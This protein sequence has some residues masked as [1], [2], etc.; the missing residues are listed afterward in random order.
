MRSFIVRHMLMAGAGATALGVSL[1]IGAAP[2]NAQASAEAPAQ[3]II[4]T[5]SRIARRD[6]EANSPLVTVGQDSFES[7]SSSSV[8]DTLNDLPQFTPGGSASLSSSA[9][10][11]F[12][13]ADQAP[14]AATLDLRGLGANR[15]LVLVNGRRAQPV[16]AQLVVDVNTIPSSAVKNVEVITGGAAAVYGADAIAGVVNFILRDDFEGFELN[17][18]AGLSE[19]G[20]AGQFQVS[21]LIGGNFANGRGNA[22]IG[23]SWS[24]RK[25]AYQ[26][27]RKFYTNAWN[28]PATSGGGGAI[29][30]TVAVLDGI[31]YGVNPD[32][33]LFNTADALNPAAP[34]TGP[35][36]NLTGGAGLKLNPPSPGSGAR[37]VGYNDP[38]NYNSIPLKRY[39]LFGAAH[40]DVTD[41]IEA[42]FEGNYTHSE[43]YAQ[44]FAGQAGNIW[45][46]SMPYD[47]G[48]DD[49]ASPTFGADQSNFHPVSRQLAALL[50]NR[51]DPSANWT[52]SRGLNFLGRLYTETSSD[53][54]QLT[55]GLRGE[56][57]VKDWT[58]ELYGSHGQTTVVARQPQGAISYAN[59]QQLITGN[60]S[61][62]GRSPTI[63]G[64]WNA[65]WTSGATFNPTSCTSGIPIFNADGSVP[66]PAAGSPDG[67]IVSDDCKNYATLELNNITKLQQ[68]I[69]EGTMQG[70]LLNNWA[71]EVRFAVGATYRTADFSYAPDTG[72]SG[73]QP[74]TGVVN[75][76]ALPNPTR[77]DIS[78]KEVYGELLVPL[79]RDL[80][81]IKQ[82]DLEL[83][84]RYSK[85][86]LSG[87]IGT[88]KALADWRVTDWLRLRGGYQKANRAPNIYELF[89]PIA[90]GLGTSQDPCVNIAGFTPEFGNVASNPNRVN[91]QTACEALIVRDGGFDYTTLAEDPTAVDQNPSLYPNGLDRTRMS[92]HRWTLGYNLPFPF[93]IGLTQGNTELKSEKADTI[94]IGAVINA[95]FESP[96][97]RRLTLT[98][99]YYSINLKGTIGA[100]NGVEIYTQCLSPEYN[101]RMSSA[102]GT[103]D[104]TGLLEG[105]PFCALINRYPFDEAGVR[106]AVGSGTDRT[107][108]APFLNKG[109]TKTSGV[110][111]T[112]NWTFDLQDVGLG[113]PGA[114]NFNGS[115]NILLDYK[116]ASFE[117]ASFVDLKG[118]LD[119][120]AFDYK[121]FGTLSY[122]WSGG[123]VGL[124]GRYLPSIAPSPFSAA[125]TQG[126]ASHTEFDLFGRFVVNDVIEL[127]AGVDNLFNAQPEIV[128]ATPTNAN[129]GSTLSVYD[130]IGRA[131]YLGAKIRF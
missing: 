101:S 8:E 119:N 44:S 26:R 10:T 32:G 120:M 39:T 96:L 92:N 109:G 125:G 9:G 51:A 74:G 19:H 73:E 80:P 25:P 123:S 31:N 76:I 11:A 29:P 67:V 102:A 48:N 72:N 118:T 42:F 108:Q 14:G 50:N 49:P 57:G 113:I 122:L 68:N 66:V 47:P 60:A 115:A 15:T 128:G 34:Y 5:G 77:G 117:G 100:P 107:Y 18:Q 93:S 2:A 13:G 41:N 59:L 45:A 28:D 87:S 97:L 63:N 65:G 40:Y 1:V 4:V 20:D 69:V 61:A 105:N 121:L 89:A 30:V 27:N 127:R 62:G 55:A 23:L 38:E 24:D 112:V 131:Y 114:L 56:V 46:L 124:R 126:A 98:V 52:M 3:D 111:V 7:R 88:F 129:S 54:H 17:G 103:F 83:G 33:S 35:L 78:V 21:G 86:S 75:Q 106:G 71:G 82:F 16:N 53:I 43:A 79:L 130:T 36:N 91:L 94:T 12:T 85:Y 110:D 99:D 90:G 70:A 37:S 58:W 116:E 22:M 6:F 81:L 95:P 84:G 104:G 64:P